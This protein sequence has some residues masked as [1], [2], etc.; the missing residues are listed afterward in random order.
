M[1]GENAAKTERKFVLKVLKFAIGSSVCFV[2]LG[3]FTWIQF[4]ELI[5]YLAYGN[6]FTLLL[7]PAPKRLEGRAVSREVKMFP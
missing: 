2:R 5:G 7:T 4:D 3:R 1:F 6:I